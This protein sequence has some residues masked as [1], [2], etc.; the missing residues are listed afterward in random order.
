M[1]DHDSETCDICTD[2]RAHKT[3]YTKAR[4]EYQRNIPEGFNVNTVDM[5]KVILLP[6]L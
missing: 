4:I 1:D 2:G 5:Q 3:A 6:K